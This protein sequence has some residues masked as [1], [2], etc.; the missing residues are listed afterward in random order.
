MWEWVGVFKY[1]I[2]IWLIAI[3]WGLL[4]LLGVGFNVFI[5]IDFNKWWAEGN[6]YLMASTI[7]G[8]AQY[9][10]SMLLVLE[11]DVW[12]RWAKMTRFFSLMLA[13]FYNVIFGL[14][15]LKGFDLNYHWSS[16]T[17]TPVDIFLF[18]FIIYN[19]ICHM[20]LFASNF[21]III[22]EFSMEF[23]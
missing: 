19:T 5:N 1:I 12:L 11:V 8:V 17:T 15:V 20:H 16:S 7:A 6:V 21:V 14:S 4:G 22:K 18:L 10:F 23:F 3:P 9:I 13:I 2:N